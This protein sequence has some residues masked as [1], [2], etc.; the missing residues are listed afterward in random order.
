MRGPPT[1]NFDESMNYTENHRL[2]RNFGRGALVEIFL[3]YFWFVAFLEFGHVGHKGL[4]QVFLKFS[5]VFSHRNFCS[6][7]LQ[8]VIQKF[9]RQVDTSHSAD[10]VASRLFVP[11]LP[12]KAIIFTSIYIHFWAFWYSCQ[13][14]DSLW[15]SKS[16]EPKGPLTHG[17]LKVDGIPQNRRWYS[18]NQKN[19][20]CRQEQP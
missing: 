12:P 14:L 7:P 13:G 19:V 15:M 5:K 4:T 16:L 18:K 9:R 6:F 8:I 11:K 10:R 2:V 1:E 17:F 3:A 20:V